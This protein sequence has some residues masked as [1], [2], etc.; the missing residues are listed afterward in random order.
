MD[1]LFSM[2]EIIKMTLEKIEEV[3]PINNTYI[4]FYECMQTFDINEAPPLLK[5]LTNYES[6][7]FFRYID[8]NTVEYWVYYYAPV[9]G[10]LTEDSLDYIPVTYNEDMGWEEYNPVLMDKY[11]TTIVG[12]LTTER[13]MEA[14]DVE[15]YDEGKMRANIG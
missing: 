5:P 3:F 10:Y 2:K 15:S 14:F 1:F 4:G 12:A 11:Y 9:M 6:I 8:T 13:V 7:T